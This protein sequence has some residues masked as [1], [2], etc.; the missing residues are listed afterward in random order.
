MLSVIILIY[1]D[2]TSFALISK[3]E[4]DNSVIYLRRLKNVVIIINFRFCA[5][6][7]HF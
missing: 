1:I 4:K 6:K 3:P 5:V 7:Q 2:I